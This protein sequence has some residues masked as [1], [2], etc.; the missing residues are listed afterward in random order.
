MDYMVI[1]HTKSSDPP[2]AEIITIGIKEYF[3]NLRIEQV[4]HSDDKLNIYTTE[5]FDD[6]GGLHYLTC[7][8]QVTDD[9]KISIIAPI[10]RVTY[11]HTHPRAFPSR[12]ELA[13][14]REFL[15]SFKIEQWFA[16][17]NIKAEICSNRV[18]VSF[19]LGDPAGLETVLDWIAYCG[20]IKNGQSSGC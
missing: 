17:R 10:T 6:I 11:H 16:S 4:E 18:V 20:G 9:I 3:T 8:L 15:N 1:A 2:L 14:D 13:R 19:E 12:E 5:I 7:M